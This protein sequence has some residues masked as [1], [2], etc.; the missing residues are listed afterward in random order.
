M[1]IHC[2]HPSTPVLSGRFSVDLPPS[3]QIENA[4]MHTIVLPKEDGNVIVRMHVTGSEAEL[5]LTDKWNVH[6]MD[7][8]HGSIDV[9]LTPAQRPVFTRR[10]RVAELEAQL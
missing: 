7:K 8:N 2:K 5:L 3:N 10:Q 4:F 9:R 1:N 6:L